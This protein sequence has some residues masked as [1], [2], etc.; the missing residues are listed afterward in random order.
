MNVTCFTLRSFRHEQGILFATSGDNHNSTL[1]QDLWGLGGKVF[2]I[3]RNGNPFSGNIISGGDARIFAY[4]LRNSQGIAMRPGTEQIYITSHGP[5]YSDEVTMLINGGNSGWDP[6]DRPGLP[7]EEDGNPGE[8]YCGYVGDPSTMPMTDFERFPDAMPP[9][10][11]NNQRSAG[12]SPCI[13]LE[14]S[15]WGEFEGWLAVGIMGGDLSA[16]GDQS[17][18]LIEVADSGEFV[19]VHYTPTIPKGRYRSLIM[20]PSGN[21]MVVE[22][23]RFNAL[24]PGNRSNIRELTPKDFGVEDDAMGLAQIVGIAAAAAAALLVVIGWATRQSYSR[25][26]QLV[27]DESALVADE[28]R[29]VASLEVQSGANFG[30]TA[31]E[32]GGY[33]VLASAS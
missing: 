17:I 25:G 10:W 31:R 5:S 6:K 2:A 23:E 22:E 33:A 21:L 26:S 13:F 29:S 28:G 12:M 24:L 30:K 27:V 8:G 11:D 19:S 3:D 32:D 14:G 7:C 16:E 15:Q 18:V 4:G 9:V 20:A 1:P